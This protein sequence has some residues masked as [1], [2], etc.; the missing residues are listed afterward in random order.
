MRASLWCTAGGAKSINRGSASSLR[1]FVRRSLFARR[2]L[3]R[4]ETK[5]G[6]PSASTDNG[7]MPFGTGRGTAV[8]EIDWVILEIE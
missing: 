2:N 5:V 3:G 1:P 4:S 7:A 8:V 6:V